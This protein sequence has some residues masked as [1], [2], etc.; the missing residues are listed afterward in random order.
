MELL[1]IAREMSHVDTIP[2]S[3]IIIYRYL[4]SAGLPHILLLNSSIITVCVLFA[5]YM[6]NIGTVLRCNFVR[7]FSKIKV[8]LNIFLF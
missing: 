4:Y 8:F 1:L 6:P 7:E 3:G 2:C 5:I